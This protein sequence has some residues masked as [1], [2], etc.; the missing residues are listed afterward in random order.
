L[1]VAPSYPEQL[2]QAMRQFVPSNFFSRLPVPAHVDWTP[3]RLAWVS[4][5]MAWDEGQTLGTRWE[6]A[7]E[8]ADHL[9]AHWTLGSSYSGFTKALVR[10]SPTLTRALKQRFQRQ[11]Q[12]L[13]GG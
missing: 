13:A 8:A 5:L 9:H 12:A 10:T 7:C 6:H 3:Q 1:K 11:M 4:L 2:A